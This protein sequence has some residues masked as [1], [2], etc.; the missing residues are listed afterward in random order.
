[1]IQKMHAGVSSVMEQVLLSK[2]LTCMLACNKHEGGYLSCM[3]SFCLVAEM[4][5]GL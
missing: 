3:F 5:H 4:S 2:A 1:M